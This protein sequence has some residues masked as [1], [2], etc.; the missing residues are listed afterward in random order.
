MSE[1]PGFPLVDQMTVENHPMNT[2]TNNPTTFHQALPDS[3]ASS[4]DPASSLRAAA[5]LTLK[6]KR[7]KPAADASVALSARQV[8]TGIVLNYGEDGDTPPTTAPTSAVDKLTRTTE[9]GDNREEGEIS[10]TESN[11]PA[12]LQPASIA[13]QPD[14]T[15]AGLSMSGNLLVRPPTTPEQQDDTGPVT[16]ISLLSL[17]PNASSASLQSLPLPV[18]ADHV[19]PGL[20]SA[21]PLTHTNLIF[22]T[23]SISG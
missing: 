14:P 7:R 8:P 18:D 1:I 13:R 4:S 19:R 11:P 15:P 16:P 22:L 17:L 20:A 21:Y 23:F 2:T 9:A 10:D 6:S 12:A 3:A 5:L